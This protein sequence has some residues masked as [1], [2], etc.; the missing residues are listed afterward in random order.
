MLPHGTRVFNRLSNF[1]RDEY[2]RRGYEEVITPLIYKTQLWNTSGHLENYRDDM[3]M[4]ESED[5]NEVFGLKPM[6]CPGHCLIFKESKV[7]SYRDLPVRMADFS[8]LHRNEASGALTGLTRVRRFHQDDAH[9]FCTRDQVQDEIL[10]CLDFV[11][12][13]YHILGFEFKVRQT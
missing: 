13:V 1:I 8:A 7:H 5:E 4:I 6:N 2:R 11:R 10:D 12:H 9:I 3:F